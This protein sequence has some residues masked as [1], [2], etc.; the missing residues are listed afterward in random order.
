M[1]IANNAIKLQ[2]IQRELTDDEVKF[3]PGILYEFRIGT[4]LQ[5]INQKYTKRG[6]FF[7]GKRSESGLIDNC[8]SVLNFSILTNPLEAPPPAPTSQ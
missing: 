3:R 5:L 2:E 4:L 7:F 1:A 8:V 6:V